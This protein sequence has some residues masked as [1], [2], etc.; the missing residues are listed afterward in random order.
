M[1]CAWRKKLLPFNKFAA[2]RRQIILQN[3]QQPQPLGRYDLREFCP[4]T[5][6]LSKR[7]EV[8]KAFKEKL[9]TSELTW[10][11]LFPR[12]EPDP[13][14][15][16]KLGLFSN[17]TA[18]TRNLKARARETGKFAYVWENEGRVLLRLREGT[19]LIR[20]KSYSELQRAVNQIIWRSAVLL[21]TGTLHYRLVNFFFVFIF[22]SLHY[23]LFSQ[24]GFLF[25]QQFVNKNK[26]PS[27]ASVF[28]LST[29]FACYFS[30]FFV[31]Y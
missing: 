6:Q 29:A 19:P 23:Y 4:T 21:T 28:I 3:E 10:S 7:R 18:Y 9:K 26:K 25:I 24:T 31:H 13:N 14:A 20:V 27:A 8:F 16:R 17:L 30:E 1:N 12:T 5:S 11:L 22:Y 2:K 15:N